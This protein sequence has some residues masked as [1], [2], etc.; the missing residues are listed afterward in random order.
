MRKNIIKI[1]LITLL[2]LISNIL[3]GIYFW[4]FISFFIIYNIS[5]LL[6]K[7]YTNIKE[8]KIIKEKV[9]DSERFFII[10][11][12]KKDD[13]YRSV[14]NSNGYIIYKDANK[15]LKRFKKMLS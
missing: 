8:W 13:Y 4:L 12:R 11:K 1:G 5:I 14:G 7:N 15:D 3:D 6:Y 10:V 2:L 9:Y